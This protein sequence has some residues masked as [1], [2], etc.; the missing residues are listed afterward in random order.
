V[1]VEVFGYGCPYCAAFQPHLAAWEKTLPA[2][3]AFSYLPATFGEG[4][5]HCWNEF[6]RAFYAAQA[7][8]IQARSHDAIYKA[9]FEQGRIATCEGIAPVYADYG[10]DPQVFASTM[11]GFA[12]AGKVSAAHEQVM[13]WGVE[14]T[15]TIVIDG[16]YRV[17]PTRSGGPDGMLRTVDWLIAQQRPLHAALHA[18]KPASAG[19]H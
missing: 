17:I 8:G 1:V 7:M 18:A 10:A 4:G 19:K 5:E 6:A 12:V 2:D 3:V 14:G 16:K 11:H 9:K 15:P 13:R